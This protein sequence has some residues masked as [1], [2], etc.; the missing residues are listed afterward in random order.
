MDSYEGTDDGYVV[1]MCVRVHTHH[2][3]RR[4]NS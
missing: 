4:Q 2:P 1:I 3:F